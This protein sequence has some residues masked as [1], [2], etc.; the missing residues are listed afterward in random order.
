MHLYNRYIY[1]IFCTET[2]THIQGK[3]FC[4]P[5]GMEIAKTPVAKGDFAPG[6][7]PCLQSTPWCLK[8]RHFLS[9]GDEAFVSINDA[10]QVGCSRKAQ[11]QT[12]LTATATAA[13]ACCC[14][15]CT[16]DSKQPGMR[17][18]QSQQQLQP[19]QVAAAAA[20]CL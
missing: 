20:H 7:R 4:L 9:R 3:S 17:Q 14:C 2:N 18:G 11:H 15:C 8:K 10:K 13:A 12:Q 19:Q 1:Y 5:M 16:A 6:D